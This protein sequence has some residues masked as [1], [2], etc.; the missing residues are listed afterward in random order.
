MSTVADEVGEEVSDE[1][2]GAFETDEVVEDEGTETDVDSEK[3]EDTEEP[4]DKP[5]DTKDSDEGDDTDEDKGEA[6]EGEEEGEPEEKD[7][8]PEPS[9]AEKALEKRVK[10]LEAEVEASKSKAEEKEDSPEEKDEEQ[11]EVKIA[12]VDDM[13]SEFDESTQAGLK[14]I[15]TDFPELKLVLDKINENA[16]AKVPEAPKKNESGKEAPSTEQLEEGRFWTSLLKERPDASDI[17]SSKEFGKWLDAQS[18]GVQAMAGNLNKDDAISLLEAYD[19]SRQR[20]EEKKDAI[21]QKKEQKKEIKK[22]L[23]SG[24]KKAGDSKKSGDSDF[25]DAFNEA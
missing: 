14:E 1:F 21:K 23:I 11:P 20:A 6:D 8:S 10:E 16:Q 18:A 2:I 5:D 13:V 12:S 22:D 4:E 15:F 3:A 17:S 9:E 24:D 25:E 7:S 19:A